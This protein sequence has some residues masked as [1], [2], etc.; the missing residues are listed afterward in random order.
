[1]SSSDTGAFLAQVFGCIIGFSL[2]WEARYQY[3]EEGEADQHTLSH[4]TALVA[5]TSY[6]MVQLGG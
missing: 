4:G 5:F 6:L 2:L 1:M 3:I